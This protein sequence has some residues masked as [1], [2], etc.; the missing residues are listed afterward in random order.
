M[1]TLYSAL[2]IP[3]R[4]E[5]QVLKRW[6]S[7]TRWLRR[8]MSDERDP[9][10]LLLR[11]YYS[12]QVTNKGS[13]WASLGRGRRWEKELYKLLLVLKDSPLSPRNASP[14]TDS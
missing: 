9:G 8:S 6:V 10:H 2:F 11:R 1:K 14:V 3:S 13:E 12:K 4:T 7:Q 5:T